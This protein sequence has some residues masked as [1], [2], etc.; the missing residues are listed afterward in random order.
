M[1]EVSRLTPAGPTGRI[2]VAVPALGPHSQ[3]VPISR[4]RILVCHHRDGGQQV[5][6]VTVGK[7]ST[8]GAPFADG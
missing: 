7:A 1:L 8:C 6:L 5:D 2:D 3:L 4:G